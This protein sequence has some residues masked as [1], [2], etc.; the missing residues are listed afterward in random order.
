MRRESCGLYLFLPDVGHDC[1][2]FVDEDLDIGTLSE[3]DEDGVVAGHGTHDVGGSSVVDVGSEDVGVAWS[4][5][6]DGHL[7]GDLDAD[8]PGERS[9]RNAVV[10][11]WHVAVATLAI[12]DFYDFE[13]GEISGEGGLRDGIAPFGEEAQ[14]GL[15]IV[16]IQL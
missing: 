1:R 14:H 6:D 3:D 12:G 2:E 7:S 10:G 4:G 15:L 9:W 13:F 11:V 5:A 8:E 16:R